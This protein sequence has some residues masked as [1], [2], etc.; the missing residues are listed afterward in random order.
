[1][2]DLFSDPSIV[3]PARAGEYKTL[4][5][6]PPWW[7]A[8]GGKIKRGADRHY[9][10]MKTRDICA[11]PVREWMAEDSHAYVWVTNNFLR[12][13]FEVLEA[14]GYRYVTMISW[15]KSKNRHD[16][17]D[18]DSQCR[19]ADADL[20]VGLGQYFRGCTEHCLF[21]VRGRIP[22][23]VSEAGGRLQGRTGFHAPRTEHSEKPAKMRQMIER[24]SPGGTGLT[25][26]QPTSRLAR[27]LADE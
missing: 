23:Q 16:D 14:W 10:L 9:P 15:F 3:A 11:L 24:V 26:N 7:E 8:G 2:I 19:A 27:C 25:S 4:L 6:D 1:M 18:G 12:D 13:G 21:G 22:Y 20:Q 5:S 17:I